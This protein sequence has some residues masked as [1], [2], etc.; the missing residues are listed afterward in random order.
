M[1]SS[2]K[3]RMRSLLVEASS[4]VCDRAQI[5]LGLDQRGLAL[6]VVLQRNGLA[7]E[8]VLGARVLDLGKIERR[9]RLVHAGHRGDV[10][11]LRLHRIGGFDHEQRLPLGD[12]VARPHQQLGEPAGIGREH[13]RRA[14]LIDRD[15]AFGDVF[16]PERPFGDGLDGQAGPFG[17]SRRVALP[18]LAGL[19]RDFRMLGIC[20]AELAVSVETGAGKRQHGHGSNPLLSAKRLQSL[21]KIVKHAAR[22]KSAVI[23]AETASPVR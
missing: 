10:V 12:V 8:Q 11:V 7:F 2:E 19:S 1:S 21:E 6:L 14:I 17:W 3:P 4:A 23:P 16:G 9:L 22:I 15:L 18:A 20:A 13:R 5:V